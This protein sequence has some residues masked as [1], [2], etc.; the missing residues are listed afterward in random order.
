MVM[1]RFLK[2]WMGSVLRGGKDFAEKVFQTCGCRNDNAF[3]EKSFQ[4]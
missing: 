1:E 4:N 3:P 2:Q